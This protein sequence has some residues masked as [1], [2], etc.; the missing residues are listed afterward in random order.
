MFETHCDNVHLHVPYSG[1]RDIDNACQKVALQRYNQSCV[2]V[3]VEQ[4]SKGPLLIARTCP[5]LVVPARVRV[6]SFHP[7][8]GGV[9]VGKVTQING[10][11]TGLALLN[12]IVTTLVDDTRVAQLKGPQHVQLQCT[13]V[14]K[15]PLGIQ[16][17]AKLAH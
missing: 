2:E 12:G 4:R 13:A 6:T 7:T 10:D 5:T 16:C 1:I 17:V 8:V 3:R 14:Y 9:Y 15:T 11:G